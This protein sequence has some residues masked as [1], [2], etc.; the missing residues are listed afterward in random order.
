MLADTVHFKGHRC[1]KNDWAG[2]DVVR[3]INI[4]IG[5]NNTGKSHLLDLVE[6]TCEEH[7][8]SK[9]PLRCSGVIDYET[10]RRIFPEGTSGGGLIGPHWN[11]H[12]KYFVEA[13]ITW[14]IAP[15]GNVAIISCVPDF[16]ENNPYHYA[17]QKAQAESIANERKEKVRLGLQKTKH[18]LSSTSFR[19]LLADRD[20]QPEKAETDLALNSNGSGATN[21]IRRF[22]STSSD[23]Y[24]EAVVRRDLLEALNQIFQPDGCF[25]RIDVK[26]HDEAPK[27]R[28]GNE[29]LPP[30]DLWEIFLGEEKKGLI[31]LSNS[32][33]GLKTVVLVL[34]NLLVVPVIAGKARSTFTFA[35]EELENNLHPA[36]LRRLLSYLESYAVGEA[37]SIFLTTHSS[38]A[39][40]M[41]GVSKNAQI[42]HVTHDGESASCRAVSAHFDKLDVVSALGAKPSDLLQANG[43][44]WVEGPSDRLYINRWLELYTDGKLVEGR[45]YQCAFYGGGLLARTQFIPQE[46]ADQELVNL[47]QIN[48]NVI[49]ICDSDRDKKSAALKPRVSRIQ[50]EISKLRNGQVWVLGARE[51]EN[52]LPGSVLASVHSIDSLPDPGQYNTFFPRDRDH[53]RS[54]LKSQLNR[55]GIDKV[56]LA[57][58]CLPLLTREAMSARFDWNSQM[59]SVVELIKR[60]NS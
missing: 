40:D 9:T 15:G 31:P 32:G 28:V 18:R 1:F 44:I 59:A 34:L 53:G 46:E 24:P 35:F 25:N 22:L 52:Y 54:Y 2:L 58:G 45:D 14:E 30:G 49:V 37:V 48:P 51:I 60:W 6:L 23:K 20:I 50:A 29:S 43:I 21:I 57:K 3:P 56:Q 16:H 13:K 47:L 42:V 55:A 5:R 33:S 10:L 17:T 36:L 19:R 7:L 11:D 38:A 27:I 41:F 12:G 4:V 39:L 8:P 26:H